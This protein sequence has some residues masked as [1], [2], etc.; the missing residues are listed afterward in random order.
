M[1]NLR[2]WCKRAPDDAAFAKVLWMAQWEEHWKPAEHS[3]L[4]ACNRRSEAVLHG[5]MRYGR[6]MQVHD[7]GCLG[8]YQVGASKGTLLPP[9]YAAQMTYVVLTCSNESSR[10]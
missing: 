2:V 5:D 1:V 6:S 9:C 10:I 7:I 3:H 8:H 4:E